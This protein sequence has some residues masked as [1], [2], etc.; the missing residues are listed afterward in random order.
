MAKVN[1]QM[2]TLGLQQSLL[3]KKNRH[4]KLPTN[5]LN[6]EGSLERHLSN[7][8]YVKQE[9]TLKYWA[10]FATPLNYKKNWNSISKFLE[11]RMHVF[12]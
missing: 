5:L 7:A 1:W 6:K 12:V 9:K 11:V 2:P 10:K 4:S 8:F 3:T